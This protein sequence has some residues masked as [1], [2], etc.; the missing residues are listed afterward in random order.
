M[1]DR[2]QTLNRDHQTLNLGGT[3]NLI[4]LNEHDPVKVWHVYIELHFCSLH[5]IYCF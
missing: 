1:Y 3:Y 4:M 5:H 2:H